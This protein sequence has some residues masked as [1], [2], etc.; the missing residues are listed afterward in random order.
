M[1]D[2]AC[3]AFLAALFMTCRL[4]CGAPAGVEVTVTCGKVAVTD[5]IAEV[6]LDLPTAQK[7]VGASGPA[8]RVAV[9]ETTGP[10]AA[11]RVAS[12]VDASGEQGPYT[13]AWQVP[14][15]LPAQAVRTFAI[16]FEDTAPGAAV[17][18]AVAVSATDDTVTVTNGD[19][20]LEHSRGSGGMISRV[21]V[22][23]AAA[24]LNWNDK[25]FDGQVYYLANHRAGKLEVKAAG[26]LRAVVEATGEYLDAEAQ[27]PSR[28]RALYRFTSYA[29]MPFALVEATVTQTFAH[30]WISLHFIEMQIGAAGFT[31]Y[32]TEQ[33]AGPLAQEGQFHA[34]QEWAAVYNEKVLIA[35]CASES[36]GVWDGG[37]GNYGAYLRSGSSPL[38]TVHRPWRGALVFGAGRQAL[39]AKLV[40]RWSEILRNPPSVRLRFEPLEVRVAAAEAALREKEGALVSLSGRQWAVGHVAV[41]LAGVQVASARQFL[42]TGCF[43][44]AL[45]A[46]MDADADLGERADAVD[47]RE[48]GSIMAGMVLDC[49]FLANDQVAYVWSRRAYGMGI[50]SIYDRR[51]GREML[52]VDPRTAPLWEIAVKTLGGGATYSSVGGHCGASF[53]ADDKAG[54]L[55]LSWQGNDSRVQVEMRLDAG[56]PLLHARLSAE[57]LQSNTGLLTVTFPVIKGILPLTPGA[58]GDMVLETAGLGGQKPSPLTS[59]KI[60]S[61]EYP[62]GMQFSALLGG[63]RGFY[64]A[65]EDG[66]ANR[67]QLTWTPDSARG[68]LDFAISHPVLNWGAAKPVNAYTSPGAVVCGPFTG[69]WYDAARLYRGWALTAPW[70]A[71]G[72]I[73]QRQDY[74]Q[75][76]RTAPYWTI[77]HLGDESGIQAEIEKQAFYGIPTMI[78]HT[79]GYFFTPTQ[80]D[81]FPE[82]WPP[83]LGSEGF[84][85]AVKQLQG[86]GIRI[87]PYILG[88]TWDEGTDSFRMKDAKNQGAMWGPNGELTTHTSYGGGERFTAMCPASKLWRDEM[89]S[90]TRELVGRYGV[91]GVYYDFLTIHTSD[92]YNQAHGHAI[93]GGNYWTQAVHGLYEECRALAKELNP[94]A[95][96]TGEDV[97]E[98]CIDVHDTFLCMG[99]TGTSA[100]LFQAV[101]HGYANVFGA[102]INQLKTVFLGRP[103]L[104]GLQNGWHN[105]E[106]PMIGKAPYQQ[107]AYLGEYYRRLLRCRW[108]FANPYLG[109]GEML[110][111]PGIAGD[112]PVISERDV[113]GPF[114]VPAVEGSAWKAPDGSVGLFFLNYDEKSAHTFT[115]TTDLAEIAGLDA[116][117]PVRISRWTPAAGLTQLRE[118]A[119]GVLA[120]TLE[121]QPLDIVAYKVEKVK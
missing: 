104:L 5:W 27:A 85:Q 116:T 86:K 89:L 48:Q 6:T 83:K 2:H 106:E 29:G 119:G 24:A 87:V 61:T 51:H 19:L 111:P 32:A 77:S 103:W 21:T 95:M 93:G 69:D 66:Q 120:E 25:I 55:H 114:T 41:R 7:L 107:Y 33:T 46:V 15:E 68:T 23:G 30:Q 88:W 36:A 54:R 79:Y 113:Y 94:E 49:P 17:E 73:Y 20:V 64:V 80:D 37:G 52:N 75:W 117:T 81:R 11:V 26:P 121:A 59:G 71:K 16:R 98:Y 31:D 91:D 112:L 38:D 4:T 12:Q 18:R 40:Q 109:W 99:K 3:I 101:Y 100:P 74:P 1:K 72:P 34:G 43:S 92:C 9:Y 14:G 110:R 22:A 97:A 70:C 28:P 60:S 58:T 118:M 82:A 67:K 45:A 42:A 105:T 10:D 102:D 56:E 57:T 44:C 84:R 50:M 108:E 65:E 90:W 115:W 39:D 78:A 63:G 47:L 96:I 62:S 76:L 13:V 8:E 35:A 53:D